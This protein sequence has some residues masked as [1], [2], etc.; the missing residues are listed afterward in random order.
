MSSKLVGGPR[1]AACVAQI[2]DGAKCGYVQWGWENIDSWTKG[3][4]MG[5]KE[6][7]FAIPDRKIEYAI[8]VLESN[9]A[10][11]CE[12][13]KCIE[14]KQ[15]WYQV[16]V[17][18][19]L[20]ADG[21]TGTEFVPLRTKTAPI[22]RATARNSRRP[23]LDSKNRTHPV[24][25]A[26]FHYKDNDGVLTLLCQS[27]IVPWLA[28]I[29][30]GPPAPGDP[31]LVMIDRPGFHPVKILR[32]ASFTEAVI[33]LLCR[34]MFRHNDDLALLWMFMVDCIK[35]D[36]TTFSGHLRPEFQAAWDGLM[37]RGRYNNRV[38]ETAQL[39]E[40]LIAENRLPA[41]LPRISIDKEFE[42]MPSQDVRQLRREIQFEK[43]KPL[44]ERFGAEVQ[45][46]P[47]KSPDTDMEPIRV[48][49]R[50]FRD[51]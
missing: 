16:Y 6:T 36:E 21:Y 48:L 15:D 25:A 47:K 35:E 41:D 1:V 43:F 44:V 33:R 18:D 19:E 39:R 31:D 2:L 27:E 3:E 26:H 46:M 14:F 37:G 30:T 9:G 13:P 50:F 8:S 12:D 51:C 38:I 49:Y 5:F 32:P 42:D 23:D 17:D 22:W 10:P 28:E 7:E 20:D 34:D 24:G 45:K 11:R 4:R 40:K 29:E